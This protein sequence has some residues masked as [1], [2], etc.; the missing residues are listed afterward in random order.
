MRKTTL[1]AIAAAAVLATGAGANAQPGACTQTAFLFTKLA[2]ASVNCNF[3]ATKSLAAS[4][5]AATRF[6]GKGPPDAWP[7]SKAGAMAFFDEVKKQG[8]VTVCGRIGGELIGLENSTSKGECWGPPG[9]DI[10]GTY[11]E[12]EKH[13]R[14]YKRGADCTTGTLASQQ[15]C[16]DA[17]AG[18][19]V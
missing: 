8:K 16:K 4:L 2:I 9:E 6:C 12:V 5:S 18:K 11:A 3:P 10:C 7:G 17:K 19:K 15:N 1:L 13:K 14:A